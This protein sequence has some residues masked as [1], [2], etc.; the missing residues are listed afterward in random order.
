MRERRGEEKE[1][2]RR[3]KGGEGEEE[4]EGG[5]GCEAVAMFNITDFNFLFFCRRKQRKRAIREG[6]V[7]GYMMVEQLVTAARLN[8]ISVMGWS[9]YKEFEGPQVMFHQGYPE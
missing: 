7:A 6:I 2:R 4:E 5:E 8:E 9:K 1:K 3:R